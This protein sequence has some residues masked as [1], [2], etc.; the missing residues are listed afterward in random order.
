M[1]AEVTALEAMLRS[2]VPG[3]N[4]VRVSAVTPL[5]GGW[6]AETARVHAACETASGIRTLD[7]VVREVSADGLLAPY[8]LERESRI[9][10][11][12]QNSPVPV[13]AMIGCDPVGQLLGGPCLVTEFVHGEPL[14]F[15]GQSTAADDAR[16]PAYYAML[17]AI[18]ALDWTELGLDF[19]DESEGAVE[20]EI[21][22][23]EM[24]LEYLGGAGAAEQDMLTWLR[25]NMPPA[26]RKSLLHGD[27]NPANYLFTG[28]QVAAVVDWELALIGDPRL[29]LGFFAAIQAT[30]GGTWGL[31]TTCFLQGYAAANPDLSLQHL[32]YF[33]AVALYRLAAFLRA[34]EHRRGTDVTALWRRLSQT[35]ERIASGKNARDPVQEPPA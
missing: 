6:S 21:R 2:F 29:D 18:H 14:S 23:S 31:D 7:V 10:T 20:A 16:L 3:A 24:R 17:A 28:S 34:A 30:F 33:E 8:D 35:F 9:L 13:P 22:R 4:R 1:T 12:L 5:A 32:D 19:L 25:S 27:P 15:F 11:A 26:T